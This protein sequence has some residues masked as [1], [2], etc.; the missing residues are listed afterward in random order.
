MNIINNTVARWTSQCRRGDA[1]SCRSC[2]V[3]GYCF[4]AWRR[5]VHHCST[6]RAR[7]EHVGTCYSVVR[8]KF[9]GNGNTLLPFNFRTRRVYL[10]DDGGADDYEVAGP[11]AIEND[12]PPVTAKD[13]KSTKLIFPRDE[14]LRDEQYNIRRDRIV[15]GGIVIFKSSIT[16]LPNRTRQNVDGSLWNT[17]GVSVIFNLY[18]SHKTMHSIFSY[19][20]CVDTSCFRS[21]LGISIFFFFDFLH[22]LKANINFELFSYWLT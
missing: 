14:R 4:N 18:H 8:N 6:S 11:V 2:R 3:V 16:Y 1:C 22:F 12:A 7:R 19:F 5:V 15:V 9:Y 17:Y 21:V 20:V 13:V 10:H